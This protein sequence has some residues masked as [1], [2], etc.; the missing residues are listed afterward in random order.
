MENKNQK[1][2]GHKN[3]KILNKKESKKNLSLLRKMEV[4]RKV[5]SV[6]NRSLQFSLEETN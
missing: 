1:G 4:K 3:Q 6:G 2:K 5:Q